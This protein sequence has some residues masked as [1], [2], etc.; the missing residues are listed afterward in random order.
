MIADKNRNAFDNLVA[1]LSAQ[2]RMDMLQRLNASGSNSVNL[3]ETDDK[4]CSWSYAYPLYV[5]SGNTY[6]IA[7]NTNAFGEGGT[8][9]DGEAINKTVTYTNVDKTIVFFAE[10][11]S[12]AGTS[13]ACYVT[14]DE[15]FNISMYTG[16][17]FAG[18][19][20]NCYKTIYHL[21]GGTLSYTENYNPKR[22]TGR[23]IKYHNYGEGDFL[24][25]IASNTASGTLETPALICNSENWRRW[26]V[27]SYYGENL[28]DIIGGTSI[29]VNPAYT[30][31]KPND[32]TGYTSLYLFARYD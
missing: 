24:C 6:Y 8:F 22:I 30:Y 25:P 19:V 12:A 28:V 11:E 2:D 7:D 13:S 23:I 3:V 16:K 14:L 29:T 26:V 21:S 32:Y 20:I 4:D 27:G 9:T 10:A 31:Q 5:K 1:G 17:P 18:N 15:G